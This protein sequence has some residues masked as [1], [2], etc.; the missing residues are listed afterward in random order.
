VAL[1]EVEADA[2]AEAV[3]CEALERHP[4]HAALHFHQSR[5]LQRHRRPEE[6]VAAARRAVELDPRRPRWRNHLA[7][8]LAEAGRL[9]GA[10]RGPGR[11]SVLQFQATPSGDPEGVSTG[12]PNTSIS[13]PSA[14]Q[15]F[16][17]HRRRQDALASSP[18][19]ARRK[20]SLR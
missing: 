2:E 15:P 11:P 18:S 5:M 6:A 17:R 4:G 14:R 1:L 19:S 13:R 20:R 7:A 12:N 3:L 16:D 8:L 9:E 10:E